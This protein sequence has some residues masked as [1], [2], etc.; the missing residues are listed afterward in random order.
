REAIPEPG[1]AKL[2]KA[3]PSDEEL[4][5]GPTLFD[6]IAA[7]GLPVR[8]LRAHE[9]DA[10]EEAGWSEVLDEAITGEIAFPGGALRL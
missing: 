9:P 8:T 1:R 2:P 5:D 4:S 7:T 10:L 6:R 3:V